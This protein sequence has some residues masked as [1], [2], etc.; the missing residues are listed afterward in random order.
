MLDD[1]LSSLMLEVNVY[2]GGLIAFFANKTL[3]QDVDEL[4]VDLSDA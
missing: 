1:F 3:E 4:W 2:I